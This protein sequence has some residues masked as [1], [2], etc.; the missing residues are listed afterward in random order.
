MD[1]FDFANIP[2]SE[3]DDDDLIPFDDEDG[4]P[5]NTNVSHKP[6]HL[7]ATSSETAK[8]ESAVPVPVQ[9]AAQNIVSSERITGTK[10]F[11]TKLHA[12]AIDFLSEQINDWLKKNPDIVVKQTNTVTG[13]VIGKKTEP[14]II[15]TVWY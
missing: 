7:G 3:P 13:D 14:N 12:G 6:L 10:T 2:T 15:I 1:D 9:K 8:T 4:E 11:F 5:V